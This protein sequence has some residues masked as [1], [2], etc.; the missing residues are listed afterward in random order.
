VAGT[1][2]NYYNV[3]NACDRALPARSPLLACQP[4]NILLAKLL[5][6]QFPSDVWKIIW[7]IHRRCLFT[8]LPLESLRDS[9]KQ[10]RPFTTVLIRL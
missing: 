10:R 6:R 8:L 1:N 4:V 5:V 9:V 2:Y 7:T 3:T